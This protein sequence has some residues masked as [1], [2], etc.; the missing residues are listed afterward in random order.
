MGNYFDLEQ[1]YTFRLGK[2]TIC[3]K[4]FRHPK[5]FFQFP[6]HL[7]FS[8]AHPLQVYFM[9]ASKISKNSIADLE[10]QIA[11]V[12]AEKARAQELASA[13]KAVAAEQKNLA[14]TEKKLTSLSA[15]DAIK[16]KPQIAQL[17]KD[18]SAQTKNLAAAQAKVDSL[19]A[20]LATAG[21]V[22][23]LIANPTK[24]K[25]VSATQ[26]MGK[27]TGKKAALKTKSSESAVAKTAEKIAKGKKAG[28]GKQ[29]KVPPV[30][31][32][33]EQPKATKAAKGK[34]A[35]GTSSVAKPKA[36]KPKKTKTVNEESSAVATNEK[37]A[38]G[39]KTVKKSSP[40]KSTPKA[41]PIAPT[42]KAPEV[43][44]PITS[45]APTVEEPAVETTPE[46]AVEPSPVTPTSPTGQR[47]LDEE[48]GVLN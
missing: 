35:A 29:V 43:E 6:T 48:Q 18:L 10:Q 21:E 1:E 36:A 28:T 13:Q 44:E 41:A 22:S 9:A 5:I 12:T 47:S 34:P 4:R 2:A 24:T 15:K 27:G 37:P 42:P 17:K 38:T 45:E 19:N 32:Q 46:A 14:A 20:Q 40:K 39:G 7:I 8:D 16:A 33:V 23:K 26:S 11:K 31:E 3:T 30:A 25:P